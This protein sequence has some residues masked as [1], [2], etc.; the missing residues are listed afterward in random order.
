LIGKVGASPFAIG[1]RLERRNYETGTL[2]LSMND[3][4]GTFG[5]NQGYVEVRVRFPAN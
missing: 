4:P 1:A 3:V 2:L 5:D